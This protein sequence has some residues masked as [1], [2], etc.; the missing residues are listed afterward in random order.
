M[1]HSYRAKAATNDDLV[2]QLKA[3]G[4]ITSSRVENAMRAVDRGRYSTDPRLAY[5]DTPHGIGQGQTISAPH[6]H[7]MALEVLKDNIPVGGRVLDVG[8]GS[9]YLTACFAE[10]VG[11][12]GRV[13][14]IDRVPDLVK[15]AKSNIQRDKQGWLES[16]RIEIRL[17]DG[18]RT[19]SDDAPF[20]AIHVGAAAESIPSALVERLKPGGRM[21]IPVG[22][23]DQELLQVDK[24]M[25]GRIT[26]K[27]L[28]PVRYVP[29]V[30]EQKEVV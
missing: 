12:N 9:G 21:V 6:M 24:D 23:L 13:L 30:R 28:L 4:I 15:W 11:E 25:Q 5:E 14:G 3:Y 29:L 27:S 10:M 17:A 7:A 1:Q 26:K 18:W 2:N 8:S 22:T 16:G 20:D 19:L